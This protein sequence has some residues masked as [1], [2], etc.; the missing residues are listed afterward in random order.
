MTA[1]AIAVKLAIEWRQHITVSLPPRFSY[2]QLD[3]ALSTI[4]SVNWNGW[5]AC[6]VHYELVMRKGLRVR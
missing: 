4:F 1:V 5:L 2:S 6:N 3:R